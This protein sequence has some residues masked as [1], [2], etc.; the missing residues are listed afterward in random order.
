LPSIINKSLQVLARDCGLTVEKRPIKV[1]ELDSFVE[2]GACG[3]AAVITPIY[4][5]RYNN[6]DITYGKPDQAGNTL[7][8]LYKELQDIQYGEIKDRYNWMVPVK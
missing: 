5:I 6:R 2:V 7:S 3:T 8:M 4:S 1:T